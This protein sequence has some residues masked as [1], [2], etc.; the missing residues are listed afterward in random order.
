MEDA[1]RGKEVNI[2]AIQS[3]IQQIFDRPDVEMV[4]VEVTDFMQAFT[5][6]FRL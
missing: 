3:K 5:R 1:L 2:G 6:A 4:G